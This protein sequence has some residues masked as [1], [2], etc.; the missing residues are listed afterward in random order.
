MKTIT[1]FISTLL[2]TNAAFACGGTQYPQPFEHEYGHK[3]ARPHQTN[4][5]SQEQNAPQEATHT[6][7]Q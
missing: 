3:G 5:Q 2:V 6:G 4:T 7:I 1:L